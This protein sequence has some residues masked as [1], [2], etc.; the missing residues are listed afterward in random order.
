MLQSIDIKLELKELAHNLSMSHI[1]SFLENGVKGELIFA[2]QIVTL[3]YQNKKFLAFLSKMHREDLID[4]LRTHKVK[5]LRMFDADGTKQTIVEKFKANIDEI[6][7]FLKQTKFDTGC[8][9]KDLDML[10]KHVYQIIHNVQLL[11]AEQ[12]HNQQA[13]YILQAQSVILSFINLDIDDQQNLLK[14]MLLIKE[15]WC[16]ENRK[17]AGIETIKHQFHKDPQKDLQ[18]QEEKNID[19]AF[20]RI[21]ELLTQKT[22]VLKHLTDEQLIHL[23]DRLKNYEW[24]CAFIVQLMHKMHEESQFRYSYNRLT[25]SGYDLLNR[26]QSHDAMMHQI[27]ALEFSIVEAYLINNVNFV[28]KLIQLLAKHPENIKALGLHKNAALLSIFKKIDTKLH[29]MSEQERS[30]CKPSFLSLK[31]SLGHSVDANVQKRYIDLDQY[32]IHALQ[33]RYSELF[34]NIQKLFEPNAESKQYLQSVFAAKVAHDFYLPNLSN[35]IEKLRKMAKYRSEVKE[36]FQQLNFIEIFLGKGVLNKITSLD[37]KKLAIGY[38]I[39]FASDYVQIIVQ[40]IVSMCNAFQLDALYKQL[41][42]EQNLSG[43][44]IHLKNQ[45]VKQIHQRTSVAKMVYSIV[46]GRKKEYDSLRRLKKGIH[47]SSKLNS[48]NK[49]KNINS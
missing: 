43:L 17:E 8:E 1:N 33:D 12:S 23:Y 41:L 6:F 4:C 27:E 24:N 2:Q 30:V 25:D 46:R 10:G 21:I 28:H 14:K 40:K 22:S 45:I 44:Q 9:Y 19:V 35:S 49:T 36:Q 11:F 3:L 5:Y 31:G 32:T 16:I 42:S 37:F 7:L 29:H 13:K 34:T 47:Q 38:D 15:V 20:E 39:K 48:S 18:L 26:F